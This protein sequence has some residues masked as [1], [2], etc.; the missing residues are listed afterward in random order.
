LLVEVGDKQSVEVMACG[1]G[2]PMLLVPPIGLTAP[3]WYQQFA[4]FSDRY[5]VLVLHHPGYGLSDPQRD[6]ANG[7]I[8]ELFAKTLDRLGVHEPMHVMAGC[9]GGVLA[10]GLAARLPHRT[11]SLTLVGAFY[12]NFGL[13]DMPVS[14]L[15]IDEMIQAARAVSDS[16]G[17]DFEVIARDA[18]PADAARYAETKALLL[19]S[20]C[21]K[22]VHVMRYIAEIL[23][24][25]GLED[26]KRIQAPT[27]SVVGTLD[28]IVDPAISS[29]IA[30]HVRQGSLHTVVGAGH[31]PYLTHPD[32]FNGAVSDFL[33]RAES[34]I[35]PPD[36]TIQAEVV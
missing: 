20:L 36:H 7:A 25:E 17:R 11:R 35:Q 16:I 1:S 6:L 33:R 12:R 30:Q 31:Y 29:S 32:V 28:T 10:Q 24:F 23:R 14:E 13:P 26:L 27:L 3:V 34:Q 2:A 22:P 18:A 21:A 19:Q 9:F 4:H 15:S 8:V 5:R